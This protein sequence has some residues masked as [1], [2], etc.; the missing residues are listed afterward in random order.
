M[1]QLSLVFLLL[2]SLT[3]NAHADFF[4]AIGEGLESVIDDIGTAISGEELYSLTIK[5]TPG[6]T[7]RIMNISPKYQ[8][9]IKLPPGNYNILVEKKGYTSTNKWIKITNSDLSRYIRLTKVE[10]STDNNTSSPVEK[11]KVKKNTSFA[12]VGVDGIP[13]LEGGYLQVGDANYIEMNDKR[14]YKTK[15]IRG[16]ISHRLLGRLP[17]YHYVT[18]K[19]GI[20]LSSLEHFKGITIKG[21][22]K[23]QNFSLHPLKKKYISKK[24]GI[25][26]NNGP[27]KKGSTIYVPGKKITISKK[28]LGSDAYFFTPKKQL[29]AGI[30]VA[31]TEGIFWLFE[32]EGGPSISKGVDD[33]TSSIK[34]ND[35][36][37][38][39]KFNSAPTEL[40]KNG[41]P[42]F[43]GGYI[44]TSSSTFIEMDS[45]PRYKTKLV[46]DVISKAR[47]K[48]MP[49]TYYVLN[50]NGAAISSLDQFNGIAIKGPY[51]FESLSLHKLVEKEITDKTELIENRGP[52]KKGNTIYVI[53][54]SFKLRKK[55]LESDVYYFTP[56]EKL[57]PG[58]YV[59][60]IGS[61]F[62]IFQLN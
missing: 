17:D 15:I 21:R 44:K 58:A 22:H 7:V 49:Y 34:D 51:K 61:T 11:N 10:T 12:K 27:A 60:R 20:V 32:L 52:A 59:A 13:E 5:T 39:S 28:S 38:T 62:W 3:H 19:N 31:W 43:D 8:N 40:D 29:S 14:I 48:R 16:T 42:D 37:D 1:R 9:G 53:D 57:S 56:R 30:Y 55:S 47:I 41:L 24:V 23:Y 18:N 25:F 6:A 54:D 46:T 35:Q 36:L 26:E 45:K 4:K 2:F 50:K 33:N